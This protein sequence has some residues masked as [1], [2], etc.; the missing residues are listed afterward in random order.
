MKNVIKLL[1]LIFFWMSFSLYFLIAGITR[2][3]PA[4][5]IAF[6]SITLGIFLILALIIFIDL[7]KKDDVQIKGKVIEIQNRI[8]MIELQ[9]GKIKRVKIDGNNNPNQYEI[10]QNVTVIETRRSDIVKEIVV[11]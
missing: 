7:Y 2:A 9:N 10:N 5:S 4:L 11:D 1:L 3:Q 8:L 6:S